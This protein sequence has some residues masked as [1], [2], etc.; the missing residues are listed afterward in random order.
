MGQGLCCVTHSNRVVLPSPRV[1]P[2][3]ANQSLQEPPKVEEPLKDDEPLKML[4]SQSHIVQLS[5]S[6]P[7]AGEKGDRRCSLPKIVL[8]RRQS[9]TI[10]IYQNQLSKHPSASGYLE[11]SIKDHRPVLNRNASNNLSKGSDR[12]F[13]PAH[14][15]GNIS[16]EKSEDILKPNLRDNN[17]RSEVR[18]VKGVTFK[19]GTNVSASASVN[20][21]DIHSPQRVRTRY[22]THNIGPQELL[23][24]PQREANARKTH[25]AVV[26]QK[27]ILSRLASCSQMSEETAGL[28]HKV[29]GD[30]HNLLKKLKKKSA[31]KKQQTMPIQEDSPVV[32]SVKDVEKM[33]QP[34]IVKKRATT[35]DGLIF[36]RRGS[37]VRITHKV[38]NCEYIPVLES[39]KDC[40]RSGSFRHITPNAGK[41][42]RSPERSQIKIL[43]RRES[44]FKHVKIQD[45]FRE[46]NA[47]TNLFNSKEPEMQDQGRG[48]KKKVTFRFGH[49]ISAEVGGNSSSPSRSPSPTIGVEP[50]TP[51]RESLVSK[52]KKTGQFYTPVTK[53]IECQ[54]TPV[55]SRPSVI[56]TPATPVETS[57]IKNSSGRGS[58]PAGGGGR[59]IPGFSRH[60]EVVL[61]QDRSIKE[62]SVSSINRSSPLPALVSYQELDEEHLIDN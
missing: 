2:L 42:S 1:S 17:A 51:D 3:K 26:N 45:S 39:L 8:P 5:A 35:N 6:N 12:G 7:P 53:A 52:R 33:P 21:Y 15:I 25:C 36:N 60:P 38:D 61:A 58:T 4:K 18:S 41:S 9:V 14:S 13:V 37:A 50:K 55:S 16:P 56:L 30:S 62:F 48:S 43:S 40:E 28:M 47:Q 34:R 10:S 27:P 20:N 44:L 23:L 19:P 57:I 11:P 32:I 54:N 24:P 46:T 59:I 49:E 31:M 29:F 22:K